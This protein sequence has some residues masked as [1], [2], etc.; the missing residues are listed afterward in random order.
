MHGHGV[1]Y[2]IQGLYV[3]AST[4]ILY[5]FVADLQCRQFKGR[6]NGQDIVLAIDI[7]LGLVFEDAATKVSST[8]VCRS[9][10]VFKGMSLLGKVTSH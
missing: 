4:Y 9:L 1:Y 5:A 10:K 6:W 7:N 3:S 2:L 8:S